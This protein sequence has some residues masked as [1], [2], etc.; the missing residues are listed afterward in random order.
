[1][2]VA[3]IGAAAS[4]LIYGM[5]CLLMWGMYNRALEQRAHVKI[6]GLNPLAPTIEIIPCAHLD[7]QPDSLADHKSSETV[8]KRR[9]PKRRDRKGPQGETPSGSKEGRSVAD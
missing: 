9:Q 8:A 5:R 4:V 3:A 7:G 1:M 6:G 2:E